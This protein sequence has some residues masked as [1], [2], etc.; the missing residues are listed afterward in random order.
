MVDLVTCYPSDKCRVKIFHIIIY[1]AKVKSTVFSFPAGLSKLLNILAINL[2]CLTGFTLFFLNLETK[3]T[4]VSLQEI[5]AAKIP[6]RPK[7]EPSKFSVKTKGPV[8]MFRFV[9]NDELLRWKLRTIEMEAWVKILFFNYSS[10]G[11]VV[12]WT[13]LLR[14]RMWKPERFLG[15]SAES[16]LKKDGMNS[17]LN[18]DG[19][20]PLKTS[21]G[22][23][24]YRGT[25]TLLLELGIE[26][27]TEMLT[28]RKLQ[29][30]SCRPFRR[31]IFLSDDKL[32]DEELR[33]TLQSSSCSSQ[34]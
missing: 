19:K 13:W 4:K 21:S 11:R 26:D 23:L 29:W 33:V 14:S 15:K 12:P 16:E 27:A 25:K 30:E 22:F 10:C 20:R 2:L 5:K 34:V 28:D 6:I 3:P 9:I 7:I 24:E 31:F 17:K 8:S 32:K 1:S 18:L